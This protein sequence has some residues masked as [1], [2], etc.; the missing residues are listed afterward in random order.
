MGGG[1]VSGQAPRSISVVIPA[2]NAARVIG[3]TLAS[4]RGAAF[5]AG[6]PVEIVVVDDGS[7]DGTGRAAIAAG[8]HRVVRTPGYGFK[9]GL[10]VYG[11]GAVR[12]AGI[13]ASS[14]E[15]I[16][17]LDADCR[18]V[19]DYFAR[20]MGGFRRGYPIVAG[21]RRPRDFGNPGQYA[22]KAVSDRVLGWRTA[23]AVEPCVGFLRV[24]CPDGS[25]FD[26]LAHTEVRG[27]VEGRRHK[28]FHDPLMIAYTSFGGWRGALGRIV[29]RGAPALAIEAIS[30]NFAD[31][32][33][34]SRRYQGRRVPEAIGEL[35]GSVWR[36]ARAQ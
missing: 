21:Q 11:I 3:E 24:I 17:S 2:K 1:E 20:M 7:S 30:N 10:H 27:I 33:G 16:A 19:G 35:L 28:V 26:A 25:C 23:F 36:A 32:A 5:S 34:T 4:V 18:V 8:A 13:R 6:V 9:Q 29:A 22:F 14:G 31:M 12:N 15:A